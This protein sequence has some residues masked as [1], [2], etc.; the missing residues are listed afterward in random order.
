MLATPDL[1]SDICNAGIPRRG[2]PGTYPAPPSDLCNDCSPTSPWTRESFSSSVICWMSRSAR[3]SGDKL[4]SDHGPFG[5]GAGAWRVH[6]C[7]TAKGTPVKSIHAMT[8]IM[9]R[10]KTLRYEERSSIDFLLDIGFWAG[11]A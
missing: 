4:L 7:A 6:S 5:A 11:R 8:R 10:F 2:T 3:W 1:P 9:D